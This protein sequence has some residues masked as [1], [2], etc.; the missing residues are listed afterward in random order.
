MSRRPYRSGSPI[1]STPPLI[2]RRTWPLLPGF[3]IWHFHSYWSYC[4]YP[5]RAEV[6]A[7]PD[8]ATAG[9][10]AAPSDFHCGPAGDRRDSNRPAG[11][12]P[13]AQQL[14]P[15]LWQQIWDAAPFC[16]WNTFWPAAPPVGEAWTDQRSGQRSR[17]SSSQTGRCC[18]SCRSYSALRD[19][20][21]AAAQT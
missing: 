18:R 12:A 6:R 19:C 5:A 9:Y 13:S 3:R 20:G 15:A 17:R 21:T 4:W 14:G 7:F 2:L 16:S 10:W 8:T 11:L 1:A